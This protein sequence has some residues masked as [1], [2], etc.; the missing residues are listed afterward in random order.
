ML[1]SN[2]KKGMSIVSVLVAI[3]LAGVLFMIVSKMMD[4]TQKLTARNVLID[5]KVKL[6]QLFSQKFPCVYFSCQKMANSLQGKNI[7]RWYFRGKCDPGR[8][9]L[10]ETIKYR[11]GNRK[12]AVL[13]PLTR[14]PL[15]WKPLYSL[16]DG[17]ICYLKPNLPKLKTKTYKSAI[18]K[19]SPQVGEKQVRDFLKDVLQDYECPQGK[20]A[21]DINLDDNSVVCK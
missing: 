15:K 19:S 21:V 12:I 4:N 2:F 9:L 17:Y 6:R 18:P 10:V 1:F 20:S 16:N 14:I 5:E 13:D 11:R 7:G 8:G 3:S